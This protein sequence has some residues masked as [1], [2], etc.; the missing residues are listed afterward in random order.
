M[1][2]EECTKIQDAN[3]MGE[4]L[5]YLRVGIANVLIGACP[6]HFII[7]RDAIRKK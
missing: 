3:M 6:E 4:N 7:V 1:S 2:C 5:S